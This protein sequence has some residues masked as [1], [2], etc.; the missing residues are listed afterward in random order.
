MQQGGRNRDQNE[1]YKSSTTL[2][3]NNR[4][5]K[6][7]IHRKKKKKNCECVR[8]GVKIVGKKEERKQKEKT[9]AS[10]CDQRLFCIIQHALPDNK[11]TSGY[12]QGRG[13]KK[14]KKSLLNTFSRLGPKADDNRENKA[15]EKFF[16]THTTDLQRVGGSPASS[17]LRTSLICWLCLW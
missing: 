17:G 10:L 9:T 13:K 2:C 6:I 7:Q 1:K 14:K 16:F 11:R 12:S 4:M 3:D 8:K 15:S 5:D